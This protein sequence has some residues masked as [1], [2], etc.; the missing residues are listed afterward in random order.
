MT[1]AEFV[2]WRQSLSLAQQG[3][4]VALGLNLRTIHSNQLLYIQYRGR[5]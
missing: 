4:A 5:H 1:G 2:S 3:A